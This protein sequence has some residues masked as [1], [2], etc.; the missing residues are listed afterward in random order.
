MSYSVLS[1]LSSLKD[2]QKALTIM[3]NLL[4]KSGMMYVLLVRIG[5]ILK[6]KKL[7]IKKCIDSWKNIQRERKLRCVTNYDKFSDFKQQSLT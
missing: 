7:A 5:S 2:P 6:T 1:H 4:E 3:R